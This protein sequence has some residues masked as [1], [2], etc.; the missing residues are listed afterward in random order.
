MLFGVIS[1]TKQWRHNERDVVSNHRRLDCL[2]NRLFRCRSKKAS[3]L[4]VTGRC[5]GNESS[6]DPSQRACNAENVSIWWRHHEIGRPRIH[7]MSIRYMSIMAFKS[8]IICSTACSGQQQRKHQSSALHALREDNK[9]MRFSHKASVMRK[10]FPCHD[11]TIRRSNPQ[12]THDAIITSLWSRNDVATSFWRHNDVIIASGVRWLM[13]NRYKSTTKH[14]KMATIFF[15][16][17]W[18]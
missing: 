16:N 8:P 3:K 18:L 4:R 12:R 1:L 15:G 14:N 11:L 7:Y 2:L 9:Y 17:I 5:E 6:G 13:G 10:A